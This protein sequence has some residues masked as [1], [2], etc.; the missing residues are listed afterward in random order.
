MTNSR[1][2]PSTCVALSVDRHVDALDVARTSF[3]PA[4]VRAVESST[5]SAV[6]VR[7]VETWVLKEAFS[8]ALGTGLV[9]RLDDFSFE[10]DETSS[11]R[12]DAPP[13]VPASQWQFALFAPS[14]RHRLAIAIENGSGSDA[15]LIAQR[16]DGDSTGGELAPLRTS[17]VAP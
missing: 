6:A 8:K 10:F 9:R 17:Y 2:P 4:E 16:F 5:G 3:S 7:F 13:G 11:I 1:P 15:P 14:D 12:F